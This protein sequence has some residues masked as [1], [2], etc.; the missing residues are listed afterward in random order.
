MLI[1]FSV[2]NFKSIKNEICLDMMTDG[3]KTMSENAE[4]CHFIDET[5]ENKQYPVLKSA[6]ICG[7]NESG[8]SHLI[9]AFNL[10]CTLVACE[11]LDKLAW[12]NL[13]ITPFKLN[14]LSSN[15]PSTFEILVVVDGI[16]H[17]YGFSITQQKIIDEWLYTFSLNT[18]TI[19]F[20]RELDEKTNKYHFKSLGTCSVHIPMV[21]Q[22]DID[23]LKQTLN[24][25]ELLLSKI[26]DHPVHQKIVS[27]SYIR[28][29]NYKTFADMNSLH[30]NSEA[31]IKRV[32]TFINIFDS[33]IHSIKYE[34][35]QT[36][37]LRV[38]DKGK[39]ARLS[40]TEESEGIIRL[41]TLAIG[42]T[43]SIENG[44]I[45]FIDDLDKHLHPN[46]TQAIVELFHNSD[47][48]KNG[49]QLIFTSHAIHLLSSD[50]LRRDQIYF[51]EKDKNQ[52]TKF[53]SLSEFK[54]REEIRN[55]PRAYLQGRYGAIPFICSYD[56]KKFFKKDLDKGY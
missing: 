24:P 25:D 34:N 36:Y 53:Y 54:P 22:I 5:G 14:N 1:E 43:L 8:K 52:D 29:M 49:A 4:L 44:L 7:A 10:M 13:K 19:G 27:G 51:I 23:T 41:F 39:T 50:I 30:L 3:C 48:N 38:N 12:F 11:K 17:Q 2:R 20:T 16:R 33:S 56:F 18:S 42:I 32:T 31:Y 28:P 55:I 35:N 15:E 37:V 40:L 6:L 47:I 21:Y 46:I 9:E 45:L 26:K